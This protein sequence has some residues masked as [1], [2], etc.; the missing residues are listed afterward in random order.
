MRYLN[1]V[2]LVMLVIFCASCKKSTEPA[3]NDK[4]PGY[5]EDIPWPSLADSP[6]PMYRGD[7]QGTGRSRGLG[8][9]VG[10]IDWS[11]DTLNVATGI[12]I[13]SDSTIYFGVARQISGESFSAL[14]ATSQHG[15]IKW[16]FELNPRNIWLSSPIVSSDNIIY[17]SDPFNYK[18][19]A[20]HSNGLLKWDLDVGS[21]IFQ[22]GINIGKDGTIY[23]I[24]ITT[25]EV[26]TLF[27]ISKDGQILWSIDNIDIS[28][29]E[30]NGMSFSAD[31][32]TLYIP[33]DHDGPGL[34]AFDIETRSVKWEFG[35]ERLSLS[36]SPIIDSKGN[37]Y[38]ISS[39]EEENGFLYSLDEEK[40]IRW[41]YSLGPFD[42][43]SSYNLFALD[44]FGNIYLGLDE[45]VSLD[46][47][48]QFRW[49]IQ[50]SSVT[51]PIV[52]DNSNNV[53]FT[54]KRG[55]EK[56][57]ICLDMNGNLIFTM[58]YPEPASYSSYSP[59]LGYGKLYIPGYKT[60]MIS[61]VY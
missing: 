27:A 54:N 47:E 8:P 56:E 12:A 30:P 43:V 4:P 32:K 22:T 15:S 36:G 31:G 45:I 61:S 21:L 44:K 34:T 49:S 60:L 2:F 46:Y 24:G 29:D 35:F 57:I 7:P 23:A 59:G 33:G 51:S 26:W 10:I 40:N 48:G 52:I 42:W 13:G 19:C 37:I 1:F 20:I 38:V 55:E 11:I 3:E 53:Y 9:Q 25:N 39:D 28:G 6:W 5:Q 17:I 16:Q 58:A 14:V 50:V 18:F 41:S